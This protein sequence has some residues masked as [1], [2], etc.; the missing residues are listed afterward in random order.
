[1]MGVAPKEKDSFHPLSP[2]QFFGGSMDVCHL[3]AGTELFFPVRNEGAL[4]SC[5]DCH[6]AQGDGE[7]CVTGIESPMLVKLRFNVIKNMKIP[8]ASVH[9]E[10]VSHKEIRVVGILCH[11]R[12]RARVD[13]D[14]QIGGQEHNRTPHISHQGTT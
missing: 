10:G 2:W 14:C 12:N 6:S 4:F 8:S 1:M 3:T 7:I 9:Y 11:Y 5:G 13:R